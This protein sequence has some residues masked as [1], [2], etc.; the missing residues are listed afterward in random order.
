MIAPR[1]NPNDDTTTLVTSG[2]L[3]HARR[4]L[5]TLLFSGPVQPPRPIP[6]WRA[7]LAAGW[8]L[9]VAAAYAWCTFR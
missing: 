5:A 3:R 7:W 6:A 1:K 8:M 4:K 9:F 2:P